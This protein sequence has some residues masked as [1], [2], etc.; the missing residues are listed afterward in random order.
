MPKL[1]LVYAAVG[2]ML[3]PVFA[4]TMIGVEWGRRKLAYPGP[5]VST[6]VTS[7]A[8][9]A[10]VF[11]TLATTRLENNT[12]FKVAVAAIV[13]IAVMA[14]LSALLLRLRGLPVRQLLPTSTFPNAGN[15]GLPLSQL[16]FGEAGLS[17]AV[18]F[19]AV[20]SFL[21]HTA[22]VYIVSASKGGNPG[23]GALRSPV[24]FAVFLAVGLRSIGIMAPLWVLETT[25][26]LA[27]LT[28][29]L[30]LISL[31]YTLITI[32]YGNIVNG[33]YVG[34]VRLTVGIIGGTAVVKLLELPPAIAGV[35]L[36]QMMM[37]VAVISYMYAERFTDHGETAAGAVLG[38]TVAFML[39]TPMALWYVG[40][41]IAS[42]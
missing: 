18:T 35:T 11:N 9:P 6:L 1:F 30:M 27:A 31:G 8:V 34:M 17:V 36:F 29:P 24:M 16:A 40:A 23:R 41:P 14:G 22:G 38:S 21:Q 20:A 2:T 26:L 25:R 7:V 10:L 39:L 12:L 15:L 37:P 28:V 32:S 5:F 33:L 19:F 13:G 4:C 3:L 42:N